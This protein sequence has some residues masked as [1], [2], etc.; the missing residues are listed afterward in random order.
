MLTSIEDGTK[1][2]ASK[3]VG[4]CTSMGMETTLSPMVENWMKAYTNIASTKDNTLA[5]Q[6]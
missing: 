5:G 3:E 1:L 2:S 6:L 4:R